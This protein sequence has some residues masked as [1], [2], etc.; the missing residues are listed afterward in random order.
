MKRLTVS[1]GPGS[2]A[3]VAGLLALYG[4]GVFLAARAVYLEEPA[5]F[6]VER[7]PTASAR[8]KSTPSS[9]AGGI[10]DWKYF[11]KAQPPSSASTATV[12]DDFIGIARRADEAYAAG[13]YAAAAAGYEQALAFVPDNTDLENNLGL[14]LHYLGRNGDALRHL[15]SASRRDPTH[16]RTWLTLGFVRMNTGDRDGARDALARAH[17]LDPHS[18]IAEKATGLLQAL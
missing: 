5:P 2:L 7:P 9:D 13:D 16:Q 18:P 1:L 14:V 12:A 17:E 8:S 6:A 15:E 4:A 3:G 11:R 10:A